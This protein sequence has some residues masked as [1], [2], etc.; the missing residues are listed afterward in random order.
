MTSEALWRGFFAFSFVFVLWYFVCV[1]AEVSPRTPFLYV[2]ACINITV[3]VGLVND[4][5]DHHLYLGGGGGFSQSL[6]F[7]LSLFSFYLSP[8]FLSLR[9]AKI[10]QKHRKKKHETLSKL[11]RKH[12]QN[13]ARH[14]KCWLRNFCCFLAVLL[15]KNPKF[16]RGE[17]VADF[18]SCL[19][20]WQCLLSNF[21]IFD[22]YW[23]LPYF[24]LACC[25]PRIFSTLF[26]QYFVIFAKVIF[27]TPIFIG[28]LGIFG[29]FGDFWWFWCFWWF[30]I[31]SVILVFFFA[32]KERERERKQKKGEK[33]KER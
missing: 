8:F 7:S 4:D 17:F 16:G 9:L 30:S 18:W 22:L 29:D 33:K 5:D 11:G 32:Q 15:Q 2:F 28:F 10:R 25:V 13:R 20:L 3:I 24:D 31:I 26:L 12:P 14:D 1:K 27:G 19:Q 23:I 6:S 21:C